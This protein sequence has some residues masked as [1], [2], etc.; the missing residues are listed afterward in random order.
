M[1]SYSR[2]VVISGSVLKVMK[3]TLSQ[4]DD[5]EVRQKAANVPTTENVLRAATLYP[6]L[7][8]EAKLKDFVVDYVLNSLHITVAQREHLNFNL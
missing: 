2:Q 6:S 3:Q 8:T 1:I 7:D 5:A 4:S